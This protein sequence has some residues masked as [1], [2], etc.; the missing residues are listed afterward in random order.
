MVV[1][2]TYVFFLVFQNVDAEPEDLDIIVKRFIILKTP[3]KILGA[4]V[5][6]QVCEEKKDSEILVFS[7]GF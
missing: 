2:P 6:P 3:R 7:F 1:F 5:I 4:N